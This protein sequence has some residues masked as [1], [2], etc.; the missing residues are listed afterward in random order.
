[1]WKGRLRGRDGE[2]AEL[3]ASTTSIHEEEDVK[4]NISTL[5]LSPEPI[6]LTPTQ[7]PSISLDQVPRLRSRGIN[8]SESD[9]DLHPT[10]AQNHLQNEMVLAEKERTKE[11]E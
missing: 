11:K 9:S 8:P 2:D 10:L 6:E 7:N 5:V 3:G 4:P 1:M